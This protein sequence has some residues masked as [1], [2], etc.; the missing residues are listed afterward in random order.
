MAVR[1][2]FETDMGGENRMN[3]VDMAVRKQFETD[4][5]DATDGFMMEDVSIHSDDERCVDDELEMMKQK[6][7]YGGF[8]SLNK[9]MHCGAETQQKMIEMGGVLVCMVCKMHDNYNG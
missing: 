7:T 5:G 8:S 2:Q 6:Q 4:M 1:K 3:R 9:C